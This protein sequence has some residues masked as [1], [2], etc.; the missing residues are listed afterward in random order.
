MKKLLGL[1]LAMIMAVSMVGCGS[2]DSSDVLKVGMEVGYPPFEYYD[3]DGTTMIGVDVELAQAIGE[4]LGMKVELVDTAWDGIFAGLEKGDYDCIMSG[5]TI[6]SDRLLDYAFSTP[7]I[8]NYQCIV[9]LADAAVKPTDPSMCAGL[10]VGYQEETTSDYYITDYALNNNI[11]VD[12]YEY[13]KV[14]DCFSDLENGR[15]DAVICDSTVASSY[16]GD[17]SVYEQTW[18][19]NSDPEEFGVC[20]KQDN[21]E[22]VDKVN[23]ALA[24]LKADG[25]LDAILAKYF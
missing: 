1:A 4:K 18:I 5:V 14:L 22:L 23:Q 3:T 12:T 16:L 21:T 17:G 10:K 15:L 13:A 7:Y 2:K 11:T 8:E 20:I 25:T 6:T 24:D 9:T 19:Q